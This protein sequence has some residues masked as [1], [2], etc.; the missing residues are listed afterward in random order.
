MRASYPDIEDLVV[1]DGVRIGY[2]VYGTGDRTLLLPTSMPL[3]HARQWKAQVPY[4]AR[5]FRVVVVDH[6]GNGRSD[7]P[8]GA[9][10]YALEQDV[11]DMVAVLDATG[12]RSVVAV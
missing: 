12:T 8:R 4:L 9:A 1:R 11:A 3:V 6:R 2:E 5:H 10:A 7:R